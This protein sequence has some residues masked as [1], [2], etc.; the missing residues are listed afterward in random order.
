MSSEFRRDD[1]QRAASLLGLKLLLWDNSPVNDG[2]KSSRFLNILQFR[3]RE[4]WLQQACS[5]H[6]VNPMNAFH[7]SFLPLQGLPGHYRQPLSA[8]KAFAQALSTLP[9]ALADVLAEYA[10]TFQSQGLD[11]MPAD[12]KSALALRCDGISH[13]AAAELAG[14]L[15]EEYR[16][17]PDCLTE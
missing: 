8:E 9:S 17:D 16:F 1:M 4:P 7:L 5:G 13:P 10:D 15:R 3:G 11:N 14:W 12:L 2:R 6:F